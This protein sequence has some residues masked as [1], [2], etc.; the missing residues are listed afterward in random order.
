VI[1]REWYIPAPGCFVPDV[2]VEAAVLALAAA[3]Q[4]DKGFVKEAGHMAFLEVA[5]AL[6]QVWDIAD[7]ARP[8]VG[9]PA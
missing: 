7:L 9:R 6:S 3:G 1:V 8:V 4:F 5:V 2:L